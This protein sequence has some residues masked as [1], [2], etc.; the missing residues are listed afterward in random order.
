LDAL[1]RAAN[2]A[3]AREIARELGRARET[4]RSEI[5]RFTDNALIAELI[6]PRTLL[7]CDAHADAM[8]LV[9]RTTPL[10]RALEAGLCVAAFVR[11][12]GPLAPTT[13][14]W[15]VVNVVTGGHHAAT[16]GGASAL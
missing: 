2:G 9:G 7:R 13:T 5:S 10:T 14:P 3:R 4:V 6:G 1:H 15:S 12:F 16:R 11:L 8:R